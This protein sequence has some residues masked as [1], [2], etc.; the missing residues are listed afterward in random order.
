MQPRRLKPKYLPEPAA[1]ARPPK[2]EVPPPAWAAKGQHY[3]RFAYPH[4][5]S[6]GEI[7]RDTTLFRLPPFQRKPKWT[8]EQQVAFCKTVWE[9]RPCQ[10]LL[11]WQRNVDANADR[12]LN[13]QSGGRTAGYNTYVIDGQQRLMALDAAVRR[14]DG[15]PNQRS[16]AYFNLDTGEWGTEPGPN[17]G[18][19]AELLAHDSKFY[20]MLR[21]EDAE[22]WRI[23]MYRA[24]FENRV[25]G[26]QLVTYTL[27][28]VTN[29][30]DV[31]AAFRS[32]NHPGTPIPPE[33]IEVLLD[34]AKEP[35]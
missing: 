4:M 24:H 6:V 23:L 7:V 33:D 21:S 16:S 32:I 9:G 22:A 13:G 30:E 29:P 28:R 11:L 25:G 14:H 3:D 31:A 26:V 12:P 34:A 18:T 1:P 10:P 19:M 17:R 35:W 20:T 8:P 27:D 2:P 5:M 15:S